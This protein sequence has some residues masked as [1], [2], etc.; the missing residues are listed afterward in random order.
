M[1]QVHIVALYF[2][3]RHDKSLFELIHGL[4]GPLIIIA[5]A[6][7]VLRLVDRP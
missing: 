3:V 5:V 7:A 4:V 1:N 2:A 6:W